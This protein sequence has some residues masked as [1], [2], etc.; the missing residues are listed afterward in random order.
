LDGSV[1]YSYNVENR[2]IGASG[3]KTAALRYDPGGRLYETG[4]GTAGI[5]RL[6]ACNRPPDGRVSSIYDG[7]ALVAEYSSTGTL[8]RR[9]VHGPG[10]DEPLAARLSPSPGRTRCSRYEGSTLTSPLFFHANHQGSIIAMSRLRQAT[11]HLTGK[12]S[13]FIQQLKAPEPMTLDELESIIAASGLNYSDFAKAIA[14]TPEGFRR[15]RRDVRTRGG[16]IGARLADAIHHRFGVPDGKAGIILS[17]ALS[18]LVELCEA[19]GRDARPPHAP[20]PRAPWERARRLI[21]RARRAG[22]IEAAGGVVDTPTSEASPPMDTPTGGYSL[23]SAAR[24]LL[25]SWKH[26][27]QFSDDR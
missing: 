10:V 23:R 13:D 4:G 16:T 14:M 6:L 17:D 20:D 25:I 27:S 24:S 18:S 7:D 26:P 8:L 12:L 5:T 22:L 15:M 19:F 9:Y 3:A 21:E 2:I 11:P 1:A